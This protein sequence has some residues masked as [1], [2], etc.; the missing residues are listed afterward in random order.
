MPYANQLKMC[1]VTVLTRFYSLGRMQ[2][3]GASQSPCKEVSIHSRCS[4]CPN[5]ALEAKGRLSPCPG[6]LILVL[7]TDTLE[8]R[9]VWNYNAKSHISNEVSVCVQNKTNM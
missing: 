9:Y 8:I 7:E 6:S 2:R 5:H 4:L 3:D 1:D